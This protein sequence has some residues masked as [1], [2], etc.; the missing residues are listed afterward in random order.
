MVT[1]N[2]DPSRLIARTDRP[3]PNSVESNTGTIVSLDA[4]H[5]LMP[6]PS[7]P[8]LLRLTELLKIVKSTT[9][10]NRPIT[11]QLDELSDDPKRTLARAHR[12]S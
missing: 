12:H 5:T 10:T 11:L 3:L 6:E 2:P 4:A 8:V 9:E 7:R 1:E